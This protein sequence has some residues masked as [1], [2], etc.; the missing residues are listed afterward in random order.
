[1]ST[2]NLFLSDEHH[3]SVSVL[4]G[5]TV[6]VTSMDFTAVLATAVTIMLVI[7]ELE[8]FFRLFLK[9]FFV[10]VIAMLIGLPIAGVAM[11]AHGR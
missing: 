9:L 1:M 5:Q 2:V 3:T 4:A 11:N 6:D 10:V 7:F 8:A